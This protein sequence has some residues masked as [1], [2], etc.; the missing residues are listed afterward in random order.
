[1]PQRLEIR[2]RTCTPVM[3]LVLDV[4]CLMDLMVDV[5]TCFV[6]CDIIRMYKMDWREHDV[7]LRTCV[8]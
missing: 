1:M 3:V 8:R 5:Y 7:I 4:I 2:G 6:L